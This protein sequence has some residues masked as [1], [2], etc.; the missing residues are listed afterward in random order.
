MR[1]SRFDGAARAVAL[2]RARLAVWCAMGGALAVLAGTLVPPLLE[3]AGGAPSWIRLVY[4]AV[5]HQV[6][7]RSLH[8]A[9]AALAVCA[10]CT[11]LYLGGVLG[12]GV[13]AAFV[14]GRERRVRHGWLGLLVLPTAA[15][16]LLAAV[17]QSPLGE[18]P[19]CA[20]A[21]PAGLAAGILLAVGVSDLVVLVSGD[22]ERVGRAR[23]RRTV[24]DS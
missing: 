8:V 14:V 20:L 24:E 15:D 21:V 5:C 3:S 2:G 13:A 7:E 10:R 18:L 16:G 11:G 22:G 1:G 6:S 12:L 4:A 19:R 9:G 17:G 23:G